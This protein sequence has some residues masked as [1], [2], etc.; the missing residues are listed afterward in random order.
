M[1]RILLAGFVM[2]LGLGC[3][4]TQQQASPVGRMTV[5]QVIALSQRGT[6]DERIIQHIDGMGAVFQLTTADLT[7]LRAAKVSDPVVTHMLDTY[8][9]MLLNEQTEQSGTAANYNYG[10]GYPYTVMSDN[11]GRHW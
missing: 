5:D 11:I 1:K 7:T 3:A 6:P 2:V 9:R 10:Y 4:T 8:T